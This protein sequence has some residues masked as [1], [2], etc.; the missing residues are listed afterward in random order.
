M[1]YLSK[2]YYTNCLI[3]VFS[4]ILLVILNSPPMGPDYELPN[5]VHNMLIMGM[6]AFGIT[7]CVLGW[8]KHETFE[9]LVKSKKKDYL[10]IYVPFSAALS[11]LPIVWG[12]WL[13]YSEYFT[14]TRSSPSW[15]Y[16][17]PTDYFFHTTS[18]LIGTIGLVSG[19]I[20]LVKVYIWKSP[21]I[22]L[23]KTEQ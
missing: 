18:V 9:S 1:G 12:T 10:S 22:G 17:T 7:F 2:G 19:L 6:Q 16:L 13:I 11:I 3:P 23:E 14:L 5:I 8:R 20:F 15:L 4:L 21:K